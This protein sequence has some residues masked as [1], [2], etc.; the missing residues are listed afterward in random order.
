MRSINNH[1]KSR[2]LNNLRFFAKTVLCVLVVFVLQLNVYANENPYSIE[3]A[4]ARNE[5]AHDTNARDDRDRYR[6]QGD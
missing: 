1:A 4:S 3:C 2:Q 6:L 5:V